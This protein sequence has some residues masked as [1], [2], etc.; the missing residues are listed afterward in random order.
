MA[1]K[2]KEIIDKLCKEG[3]IKDFSITVYKN[4]SKIKFFEKFENNNLFYVFSAGK[5]LVAAVIWKLY[6]QKKI[7]FNDKISKFWPEFSKN[8]KNEITVKDVL[9][10]SSGVSLSETL[11]DNDYTDLNR[12]SM[13]LENYSPESKPGQR[14]A[15]HQVTYGW[16]LGEIIQRITN[17]SFEESFEELVK[18]PLRLNDTRFKVKNLEELP[19][20]IFRHTSSNLKTIPIIFKLFSI[21]KIP[22]ISGTC[23]STSSDLALFYNQILH[24]KNWISE[25]TKKEILKVHKEGLDYNDHLK[26]VKLGLGVRFDSNTMNERSSN[27]LEKTF[28]HTGLVSCTGWASLSNKISVGICNNLLL[29]NTLNRYRLNNLSSAIKE[30]LNT[31]KL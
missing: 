24:N 3:L 17:K 19:V 5:P 27:L 11:S 22:L 8:N 31:I 12:I 29:S 9:T 15:Y 13:W 25:N 10:H 21:N 2:T 23:I 1:G 30:D 18:K 4:N 26:L 6:D 14:I 7:D 28:G 16:I 20:E